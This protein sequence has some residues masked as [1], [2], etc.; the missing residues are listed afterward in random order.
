MATSR[1]QMCMG[2]KPPYPRVSLHQTEILNRERTCFCHPWLTLLLPQQKFAHVSMGWRTLSSRL[3]VE[4][5]AHIKKLQKYHLQL[6]QVCN[7]NVWC[8]WVH[9]YNAADCA[10]IPYHLQCIMT[11]S[12]VPLISL[13]DCVCQFLTTLWKILVNIV[14]LRAYRHT[15]SWDYKGSWS[16][17]IPKLACDCWWPCDSGKIY[18]DCVNFVEYGAIWQATLIPHHIHGHNPSCSSKRSAYWSDPLLLDSCLSR[19]FVPVNIIF[20]NSTTHVL[21]VV[22]CRVN[23]KSTTC[24]YAHM[25]GYTCLLQELNAVPSS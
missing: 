2:V 15:Q 7:V 17:T 16:V 6:K 23:Y 14:M 18:C 12:E 5:N 20:S 9:V 10:I 4:E 25:N 8:T 1:C 21:S 19:M 3:T 13:F 24:I 22:P 11:S